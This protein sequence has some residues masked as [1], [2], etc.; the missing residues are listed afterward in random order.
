MILNVPLMML[1]MYISI[2]WLQFWFMGLF[3]PNSLDAK[4][5]KVGSQGES[6]ARKLISQHLNNMG[7]MT[8]HEKCV[9][10]LFLLSILLWFFR[11]PQFVPGW[12]EWLTDLKV[13]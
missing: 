7:P 2:I 8:Y 12:A 6:A 4:R 10:I 3:R 11:K 9:G 5:I 1:T 13:I